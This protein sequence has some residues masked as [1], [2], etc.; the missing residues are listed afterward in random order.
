MSPENRVVDEVSVG[1]SKKHGV[2]EDQLVGPVVGGRAKLGTVRVAHGK[3]GNQTH[4]VLE[5]RHKITHEH[6]GNSKRQW[7]P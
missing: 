7:L 2:Q 5:I 1:G 6:E 3:V 4:E